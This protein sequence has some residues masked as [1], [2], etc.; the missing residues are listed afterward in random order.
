MSAEAIAWIAAL[1]TVVLGVLGWGRLQHSKGR[2]SERSRQIEAQA[3]AL[4]AEARKNAIQA[5]KD[6][7]IERDKREIVRAIEREEAEALTVRDSAEADAKI[8]EIEKR[9]K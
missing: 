1:V 4:V 2:D 6:D 8:A 5:S 7:A 9:H 3:A